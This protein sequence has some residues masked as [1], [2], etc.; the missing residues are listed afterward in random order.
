MIQENVFPVKL[1]ENREVIFVLLY[2][3][4]EGVTK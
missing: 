4:S 3:E 1:T 2:W